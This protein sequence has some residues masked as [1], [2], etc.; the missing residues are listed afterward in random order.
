MAKFKSIAG[1][2]FHMIGFDVLIPIGSKI[3]IEHTAEKPLEGGVHTESKTPVVGYSVY[4]GQVDSTVVTFFGIEFLSGAI[5]VDKSGLQL[6]PGTNVGSAGDIVASVLAQH[7]REPSE[8]S[9]YTDTTRGADHPALPDDYKLRNFKE[10]V[11]S[12]GR[13]SRVVSEAV[14]YTHLRAH[15]T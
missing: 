12:S 8:G 1:S 3:N 4:E 13:E 15:E 5:R 11:L 2:H 9:E 6:L 14:S 10:A 7:I